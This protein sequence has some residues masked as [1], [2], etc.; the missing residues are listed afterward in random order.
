MKV[1]KQFDTFSAA[2][3][4]A[5]VLAKRGIKHSVKPISPY[6][7]VSYEEKTLVEKLDSLPPSIP[8]PQRKI[9]KKLFC[10]KMESW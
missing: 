7:V 2:K 8:S 9:Q 5:R 6:F 1:E 3:D 4:Y 10:I